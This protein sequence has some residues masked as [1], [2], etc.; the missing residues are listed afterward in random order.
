MLPKRSRRFSVNPLK[1]LSSLA[2]R[3]SPPLA[4]FLLLFAIYNL[5]TVK[6]IDCLLNSNVCTPEINERLNRHLGSNMLFIN[7]KEIRSSVA[8]LFPVEKLDIGF[9]VFNTLTIR[10]AGQVTPL[11]AQVSLI[12]SL[13]VL[14]LDSAAVSSESAVFTKPSDEIYIYNQ[15]VDFSSFK[16][17]DNGLMAPDASGESKIKYLFTEKPDEVN[18]KYLYSL[19]KLV[20]RYLEIDQILVLNERVFLRQLDE[21]DII[22]N[23]P[24]DEDNL[25]QAL[26]SYEYLTTIKKDAKVIDL[27]FKN[28]ILR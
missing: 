16:L 12:Q 11:S 19:V 8:T 15:T 10:I 17:W 9:K 4:I 28:P 13:P 23:I 25:V 14:S 5:F 2:K 22:V 20:E 21:P 6:K 7:Q 1:S 18:I 3:V 26:Q 24:F 27:R